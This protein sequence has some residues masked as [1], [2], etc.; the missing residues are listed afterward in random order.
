MSTASKAGEGPAAA[1]TPAVITLAPR[2]VA[3]FAPFGGRVA[4]FTA[5]DRALTPGR[6]QGPGGDQARSA[7]T[8]YEPGSPT[9]PVQVRQMYGQ[10]DAAGRLDA[11]QEQGP[12]LQAG[13]RPPMPARPWWPPPTEG[14]DAWTL[15][16]WSLV[17]APKVGAGRRGALGARLRRQGLV[18]G[19]RARHGAD[20]PGRSR[21]LSRPGLRPQQH[22]HSR[23]PEQAG[24]LVPQRASSRR[25]SRRAVASC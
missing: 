18:R 17:E 12:D 16:R 10:V 11:A 14:A 25:P 13:R 24:L 21:R 23:E 22:R 19:H 5:Q 1:A 9:W 6:A 15:K 2:K 7:L 8:V 3:G 20:H 4:G